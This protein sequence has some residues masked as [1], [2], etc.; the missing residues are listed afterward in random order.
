MKSI[1]TFIALLGLV[2]TAIAHPTDSPSIWS[3]LRK[4]V[5]KYSQEK[6]L[7]LTSDN[8][9]SSTLST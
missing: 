1:W 2:M 5:R 7:G 6:E 8:R 4:N 9:R 3:Q